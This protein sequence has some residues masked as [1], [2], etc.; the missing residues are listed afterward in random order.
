MD[1]KV[2]VST[3]ERMTT[4]I[5]VEDKPEGGGSFRSWKHML[6]MVLDEKDPLFIFLTLTSS[7]KDYFNLI[8]SNFVSI[9]SLSSCS[10]VTDGSKYQA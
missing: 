5:R 7:G 9:F 1:Q 4:N 3:S 6:Q 10:R 2:R 8:I